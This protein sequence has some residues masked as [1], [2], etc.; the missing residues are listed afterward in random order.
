MKLETL[1]TLCLVVLEGPSSSRDKS[2]M[3]LKKVD[4]MLLQMLLEI[5][6]LADECKS[7]ERQNIL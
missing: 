5:L 4:V 2:Y 7:L 1:N 6:G 3:F